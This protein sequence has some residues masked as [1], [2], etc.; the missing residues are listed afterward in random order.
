MKW[1]PAIVPEYL[2]QE[3]RQSFKGAWYCR[4]ENGGYLALMFQAMGSDDARVVYRLK[5]VSGPINFRFPS[6]QMVHDHI[7]KLHSEGRIAA[8]RP[9]M[10]TD[11]PTQGNA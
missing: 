5:G 6:K 3:I 2:P 11:T 4:D 8:M 10:F 9:V 7:A 1:E